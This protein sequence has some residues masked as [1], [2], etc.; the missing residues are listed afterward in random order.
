[1]RTLRCIWLFGAPVLESNGQREPVIAAQKA[2]ALLAYL[3]CRHEPT[4][5]AHL[6]ALLW[7]ETTDY[8]SRRNLTHVLGQL[9]TR[10]P[11]CFRADQQSVQWHPE[12]PAW[13]DVRAC[14]ALLASLRLVRVLPPD[15]GAWANPLA[16]ATALYRGDLLAGFTL[17]DCPEFEA[18]LTR[19][20]EHW[21][22]QVI[23]ALAAL[24]IHHTHHGEVA[25]AED[26]LRHW[27][28]LEPWQEEAQRTL[29]RLLDGQGRHAE[30]LTQY[31]RCRSTLAAE[32]GLAP[33]AETTALAAQIRSGI[34]HDNPALRVGGSSHAALAPR[35]FDAGLAPAPFD[36]P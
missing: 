23:A 10:L 5:R 33:S 26:A 19:E 20:R 22:Q 13:V 15:F 4:A 6:A 16:Q 36:R 17:D 32:L 29:M 25:L 12:A 9:S 24:S 11:G 35:P 27:L 28:D 34:R 8:R 14:S 1:M 30:A 7:G 31:E 2:L 3:A 21:R 18:W